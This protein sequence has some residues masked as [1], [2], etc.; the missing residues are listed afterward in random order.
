MWRSI[1][2]IIVIA[3]ITL[4][5]SSK[6]ATGEACQTAEDC[7]ASQCITGSSFPNGVCTPACDS[8]SDC[9][10]GFSC[11]SRSSGI[12]LQECSSSSFCEGQRGDEWQCREESVEEGGGNAMVC[13]GD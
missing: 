2:P 9:P 8:N 7:E 11:I 13:V 12:C 1:S 10:A 4:G 3:L 6:A 5:C